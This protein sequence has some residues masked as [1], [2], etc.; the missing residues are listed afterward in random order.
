MEGGGSSASI[1]GGAVSALASSD[2]CSY[3]SYSVS[4]S[5][6]RNKAGSTSGRLLD[7]ALEPGDIYAPLPISVVT[8]EGAVDGICNSRAELGG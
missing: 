6:A 4:S 5:N 1:A 7:A 3:P 8:T 2:I